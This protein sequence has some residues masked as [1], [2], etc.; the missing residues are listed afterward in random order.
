MMGAKDNVQ[1]LSGLG[2]GKRRGRGRGRGLGKVASSLEFH[3]NGMRSEDS[4]TR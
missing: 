3:R 2:T 4:E 1:S